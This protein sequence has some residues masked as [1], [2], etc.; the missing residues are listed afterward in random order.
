MKNCAICLQPTCQEIISFG[1]VP[2]CHHFVKDGEVEDTHPVILGQCEICGLVQM[3]NPIPPAKLVPRFEWITYNEPEAHLDNVVEMLQ[4]LP[5]IKPTSTI[6]GMSF[7]DDSLLRRFRERGFTN[8][9]RPDMA[10]DLEINIPNAGIET[11]QSKIRPS[12]A[13]KLGLKYGKPDLLIVRM[14]LEHSGDP[15][16]FLETV[17]ALVNPSGYVVF[18]VPDCGR[19]FD[20]LDYTT[21]WEDHTLYFVQQT[22]LAALK[23]RGFRIEKFECYKGPYENCLVAVAKPNS[24]LGQSCL[25]DSE[26]QDEMQRG[27]NFA[28]EFAG[29]RDSVRRNLTEWRKHGKIAL[30]GAGHQSAMFINLMQVDDL[31]AF[32]VDDHPHKC[33]RKMPGSRLPIVG[34]SALY[35]E[36]VKLCLSSLGA[37]SEPK[38]IAKHAQFINQGGVFASIFPLK[39]DSVFNVLAGETTPSKGELQR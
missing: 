27:R 22:F 7:N 35:S 10:A 24:A 4:A 38:V 5:G 29:R 12:L 32:V 36:S 14:M 39:R 11:V 9:W 21:I 25:S 19:A 18:D 16:A 3:A 33:G 6:A 13:E 20:L 1:E 31:I 17:R 34:S 28:G 26:R 30:F 15:P 8:T 23:N 37:S 2:I